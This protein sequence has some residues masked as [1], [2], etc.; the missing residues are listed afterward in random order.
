MSN[1]WLFQ[2]RPCQDE[3]I[4]Y[5]WKPGELKSCVQA[6]KAHDLAAEDLLCR[7]F[8]PLVLSTVK[9]LQ[10]EYNFQWEEL[11]SCTWEHFWMII[12]EYEGTDEEYD[13]LPGLI[14]LRLKD[15][16]QRD[17]LKSFD[18]TINENVNLDDEENPSL[19]E[20]L[21]INPIDKHI[22]TKSLEQLISTL[23]IKQ[24]LVIR[25]TFYENLDSEEIASNL[26][27]TRRRVDQL[28]TKAL[29]HLNLQLLA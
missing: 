28:R 4:Y 11:L 29:Q 15:R 27:L 13:M 3:M 18:Y 9:R 19:Q 1:S 10:Y 21:A 6:A 7:N 24:Q 22:L 23:P 26:R 12:I 5:K 20:L 8:E 16:V 14:S 25:Q 17:Y 2:N